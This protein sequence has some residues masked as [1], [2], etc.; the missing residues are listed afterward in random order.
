MTENEIFDAMID[1]AWE[2]HDELLAYR[3]IGTIDEFKALKEKEQYELKTNEHERSN[4]WE[5]NS[6][7]L[8]GGA[9]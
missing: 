5:E 9:E 4:Y 3:A 7:Q 6:E 1:N 8:K 2:E